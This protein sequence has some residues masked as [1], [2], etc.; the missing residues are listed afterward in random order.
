MRHAALKKLFLGAGCALLVVPAFVFAVNDSVQDVPAMG[1]NSWNHFGCNI[2]Q[3]TILGQAVTM[4][5][6]KAAV[7]WEGKTPTMKDAG[8]QF[9][10][11]DD[12]WEGATNI[13][14]DATLFPQGFIWMCDSIRRLGLFP[15]LYTSAGT[16]TCAGRPAQYNADAACAK[17]YADWGFQYLKEDWCNV[18]GTYNNSAGAVT[19]YQRSY[20][21][22]RTAAVNAFNAGR[23]PG[24]T[25]PKYFT[26]SLCNWG[27]YSSWTY[28]AQCGHSARMSGDIGA[29]WG[30]V[31]GIIDQCINNN[32]VTYNQRGFF[33]D[34]DMLEC[35]NGMTATE[36]QSHFDLWIQMQSPLLTG[37]DLV[38][39]GAATLTLFT[40]REA[41]AISQDSLNWG[42]RRVRVITAGGLDLWYKRCFTRDPISHAVITDQTRMKKSVIIFNRGAAAANYSI[43][44]ATDGTPLELSATQAYQVRNLWTH[45]TIDTLNTTET[46]VPAVAVAGHGTTHLLFTPLSVISPVIPNDLLEK[47]SNAVIAALIKGRRGAAGLELYVPANGKIGLF[48]VQGRQIASF[49]AANGGQWYQVPVNKATLAGTFIVKASLQ[50]RVLTKTFVLAR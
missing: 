25:K 32:V 29:N 13:Q 36:D 38:N 3:A 15:G 5:T 26:F 43:T 18:P 12:C 8:F 11:L 7:N 28:G 46:A 39:M 41:I 42:G 4:A 45:T 6:R 31:V 30:S 50:D 37:N 27:A 34:P 24:A 20:Q 17:A 35:G 21:A 2:R 48:T 10:N 14:Y 23:Y 19:L 9:I 1:W 22:L 16:N 33:N 49:M 40:N 47:N 44:R